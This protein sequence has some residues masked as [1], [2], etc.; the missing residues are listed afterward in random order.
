MLGIPGEPE[1]LV[2]LLIFVLLFGANK[3]PA[4]ARSSGRALG[5]FK[6]GREELEAKLRDTARNEEQQRVSTKGRKALTHFVQMNFLAR[7]RA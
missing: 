7:V 5:E 4:L 3:L 2:I 6:R 1:L